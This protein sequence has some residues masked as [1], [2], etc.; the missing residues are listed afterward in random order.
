LQ[1]KQWERYKFKW[2][3]F[4]YLREVSEFATAG[5]I[6]KVM[7]NID[8]DA[9]DQPP[10][11]KTQVM[12]TDKTLLAHGMP[13]ED[14][15][16]V[17]PGKLL[18]PT[19]QPLYVRPGGLPGASDIKTFDC[20][21]LWVSTSGVSD[22][23]TKLGELHVTYAV[24]FSVPVLES[25]TTA[26]IN[27]SVSFATQS[28][29]LALTTTVAGTILWPVASVLAN[30]TMSVFNATTGS[31]TPPPGNYLVDVV[32]SVTFGGL[33]TVY[34][35][36]LRKN[37]TDIENSIVSRTFTSGT[38]TADTESLSGYVSC[39]GTDVLTVVETATFSTSTASAYANIRITAI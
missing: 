1:A 18:H 10:S 26:P 20:G 37:G 3:K 16:M 25:T 28:T 27:N 30:G 22:N 13:C 14:F 31:I 35:L 32:G 36:S 6:G 33:A 2:I 8:L 21:N 38:L 19:G 15:S 39:N 11:T 34:A 17:I 4:E 24:E 9:S 29:A 12:D 7:L 5:T 23:T